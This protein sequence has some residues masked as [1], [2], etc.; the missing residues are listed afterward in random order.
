MGFRQRP[1]RGRLPRSGGGEHLDE[2][3]HTGLHHPDTAVVQQV[4]AGRVE[5]DDLTLAAGT[6][7]LD[8][9]IV[10]SSAAAVP[11]RPMA[12]SRSMTNSQSGSAS[13]RNSK[14]TV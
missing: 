10:I 13:S 11:S 3:V 7:R 2:L 4:P 12:A 14:D 8:Q 5:V 9:F 1:L 6:G